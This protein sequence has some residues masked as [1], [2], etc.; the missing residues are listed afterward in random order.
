MARPKVLFIGSAEISALVLDQLVESQTCDIVG[1]IAQPERPAG[2]H[3]HMTPCACHAYALSSQLPCYTPENINAPESLEL[4]RSLQ[5]E[6]AVVVA[7]GQFLSASLLN[8]PPKG[9]LNIHVSLLPKYRGAAP[10]Q[11]A[12]LNGEPETG[13]TIMLMD[14]GMDSGDIILQRATPIRHDDTTGSIHYRLGCIGGQLIIETLPLWLDGAL[15]RHPQVHEHATPAKKLKKADGIIN[16]RHTAEDL[17]RRIRAFNPWP[18]CYTGF[19]HKDQPKR[20]K[21][22]KAKIVNHKTDSGCGVIIQN[23][24]EGPLVNTGNGCLLLTQ[25]QPDGCR[26]MTGHDFLNGH[27]LA[28]GDTFQ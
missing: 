15:P 10:I 28:V 19:T 20:L 5:P 17:D 7:Y 21:I 24:P 23:T 16:W 4:I 6:V 12:I 13:V 25:V 9:C 11:H 2:R 18:S 22:L 27:A 8:I 1:V 26:V 14:E 3:K